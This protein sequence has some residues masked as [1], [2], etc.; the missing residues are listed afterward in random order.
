MPTSKR[1]RST[2]IDIEF[3]ER[4][5]ALTADSYLLTM[6][7]MHRGAHKLYL[8]TYAERSRA[9]KKCWKH[10]IH[11]SAVELSRILYRMVIH[12]KISIETLDTIVNTTDD[13]SSSG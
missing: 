1:Q 12:N 13:Y 11:V 10:A 7:E 6:S 5:K 8:D 4:Y 3:H 9:L 2:T